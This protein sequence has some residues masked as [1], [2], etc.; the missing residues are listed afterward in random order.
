FTSPHLS[1]YAE[2]YVTDGEPIAEG[3]LAEWIWA[4]RPVLE[5]MV[6][7]G[8]EHPTEFEVCTAI[9]FCH[10]LEQG[11]DFLVLE[12]GL[13]GAIDSTN[14]VRP[15]VTV[16]TNVSR[17]HMEQLG[18][19]VVEIAR[20]KAGIIKEGVPVVTGAHGAALEVIAEAAREKA[21][22]LYLVGRDVTWRPVSHSL[23]GQVF[24]LTGLL[25]RYEGLR[26]PLIGRHQ[27]ANAACAVA[28]VELL[29]RAGQAAVTER[30]V[31]EGLARTSW[32]GRLEVVSRRP[33]VLLDGAHNH[34]GVRCLRQALTD[35]LP[36]R[37]VILV[38][39]MLGDKEREKV[40]EEL[41]PAARAVVVTRPN[42][43]RAGAWADLAD[44]VRPHCAA[45]EV[46][47][48]PW[49]AVCRA[50]EMAGPRD[51]VVVTGS[52]YTVGEVRERFLATR[53]AAAGDA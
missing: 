14:V 17:D 21:A 15:L 26:L 18:R 39:G 3:R 19:S 10:F 33:L 2:R 23:E 8:W 24:D 30:V 27:M 9:A 5:A 1:S 37:D 11:V 47:E 34:D 45:V 31:R 29:A 25:G 16:I 36:D 49:Q 6:R 12:V 52:L 43:P 48:D 22:P 46:V 50:M 41:A 28:A 51:A 32:P 13:G 40:A 44:A 20:V 35:Y 42:S 38:I 7:D 53:G 4:L